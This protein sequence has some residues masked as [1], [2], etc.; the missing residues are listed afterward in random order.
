MPKVRLADD[1]YPGVSIYRRLRQT[2]DSVLNRY[3]G[4]LKA[5]SFATTD[6][7]LRLL[8]NTS[9]QLFVFVNQHGQNEL[10]QYELVVKKSGKQIRG[11]FFPPFELV[12]Q[13][14]SQILDYMQNHPKETLETAA[15]LV[16]LADYV[17]RKLG[18]PAGAI[19][20]KIS[21][22]PLGLARQFSRLSRGKRVSKARRRKRQKP[23]TRRKGTPSY[24]R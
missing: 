12:F 1:F 15:S 8:L 22:R 14:L 2:P 10:N 23:K 4:L 11:G 5:K 18:K 24:I 17:E 7:N 19:I 21:Q 13:L 20:R 16:V 9:K 6:G 3:L